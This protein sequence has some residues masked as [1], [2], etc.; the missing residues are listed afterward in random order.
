MAKADCL[1]FIGYAAGSIKHIIPPAVFDRG[2][3]VSHAADLL[4]DSVAEL[5]LGYVL[6]IWRQIPQFDR[7]MHAHRPWR[8]IAGQYG[9]GHGLYARTVGLIGCGMVARKFIRL[10]KPFDP[11]ILV[12]DPYLPDT[13]AAELGVTKAGLDELF[14]RSDVIS[15]HLPTTP[16]THHLIRGE[17]LRRIRNGALFINTAR[18]AAIDYDA[19][20][21]EL[22]TGRFQAALDV[23]PQEPLADDSPFR[24]L[25]NVVLTPHRAGSTIESRARL[26]TAMV[27][28]CLRFFRGE[29]LRYQVY[30]EQL[31]I[32]A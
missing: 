12:Y 32:M 27:D 5:C 25:P 31:A 8:E 23:F 26:G 6:S 16:E 24:D 18:A 17:H 28:E 13:R 10:L 9:Y 4:A 15:N 14:E 20:L 3:V 19:L 1:H 30:K 11:V 21:E 29:P 22:R 7:A 2:V